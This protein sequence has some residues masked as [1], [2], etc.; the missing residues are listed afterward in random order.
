[1]LTIILIKII[2]ILTKSVLTLDQ[3]SKVW[4]F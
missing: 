4:F 2:L 3:A 1:M